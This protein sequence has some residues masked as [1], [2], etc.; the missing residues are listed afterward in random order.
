MKRIFL[1]FIFRLVN[2]YSFVYVSI[3]LS[4]IAQGEIFHERVI[5]T[6]DPDQKAVISWS[7]D[8]KG[9]KSAVKYGLAPDKLSKVQRADLDG[10][11][12]DSEDDPVY[13]HHV[14][15]EGLE[16][17][18]YSLSWRWDCEQT[19]QVWNSCADVILE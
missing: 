19:P 2:K 1:D 10:R 6:T 3:L 18:T 13:Y 8:I 12:D 14:Q 7:S 5:W 15:L 4:Q 11:F 16:P 9:Q 17:G